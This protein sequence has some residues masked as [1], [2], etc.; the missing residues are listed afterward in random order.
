MIPVIYYTCSN[1]IDNWFWALVQSKTVVLYYHFCGITDQLLVFG[2]GFK[3]WKGVPHCAGILHLWSHKCLIVLSLKA[4]S[5]I[6]QSI[7]DWTFNL[8][9]DFAKG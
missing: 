5:F 2:F 9:K 7:F 4:M 1:G 8:N 3:H 6:V